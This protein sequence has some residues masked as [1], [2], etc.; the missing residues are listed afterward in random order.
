MKRYLLSFFKADFY[1]YGFA[2]PLILVL[3]MQYFPST[4][5][6]L[7]LMIGLIVV[8]A[9]LFLAVLLAL[10]ARLFRPVIRWARRSEVSSPSDVG[11][12]L[13]RL[14]AF[15]SLHC[16]IE[17]LGLGNLILVIFGAVTGDFSVFQMNFAFLGTGVLM[18]PVANLVSE[19]QFAL[20]L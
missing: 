9:P 5:E 18:I 8:I 14:F 6:N 17:W 4:V 1:S 12:S 16:T 2:V 19:Q 13:A 7:G 3:V 10:R 11:T 20:L 15:D